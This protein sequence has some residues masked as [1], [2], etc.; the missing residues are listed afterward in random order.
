MLEATI[1]MLPHGDVSRRRGQVVV[2]IWNDVTGDS[3]SGNYRFVVSHQFDS[4]FGMRAAEA[5]GITAPTSRELMD[6]PA[7][8]WRRGQVKGF[9]RQRGAAALLAVVLRQAGL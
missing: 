3:S 4:V 5:T 9:R 1:D 2:A 8:V 7:W 6:N